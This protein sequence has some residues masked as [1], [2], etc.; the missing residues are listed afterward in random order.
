MKSFYDIRDSMTEQHKKFMLDLKTAYEKSFDNFK[1]QE[2]E[3][4]KSVDIVQKEY[5]KYLDDLKQVISDLRKIKDEKDVLDSEIKR[6]EA[7]NQRM[8]MLREKEEMVFRDH[9]KKVSLDIEVMNTKAKDETARLNIREKELLKLKDDVDQRIS[10]NKGI[11]SDL[12][13]K[14]DEVKKQVKQLETTK[15]DVVNE[16]DKLINLIQNSNSILSKI[17]DEKRQN[18]VDL[19]V[20]LQKQNEVNKKMEFVLKRNKEISLKEEGLKDKEISLELQEV[21]L[22]KK[23]EKVKSLIE[24]YKLKGGL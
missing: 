9:L 2:A 15:T 11:L 18:S 5:H 14:Q 6:I 13:K 1:R 24:I 19:E 10:I 22:L 12:E 17:T 20:I 3:A 7:E 4:K 16:Q 21:Q 23:E 8:N